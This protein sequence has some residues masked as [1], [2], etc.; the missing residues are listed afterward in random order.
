MTPPPIWYGV[1]QGVICLVAALIFLSIHLRG[2][3]GHTTGEGGRGPRDPGFLWLS[4]AVFVWS[5]TGVLAVVV[6]PEE[7]SSL[8]PFLSTLNSAFL[9]LAASSLA[10]GMAF[11][12]KLSENPR[13]WLFVLSVTAGTSIFTL[14]MGGWGPD[15]LLSV[16]T[17]TVLTAGLIA[18]FGARSFP[19]LAAL[20]I[21][22]VLILVPQIEEVWSITEWLGWSVEAKW[23]LN[24][25]AKT[26]F[27]SVLLAL[28][29]SWAHA[30]AEQA[31][32]QAVNASER[33]EQERAARLAVEKVL[34]ELQ[35]KAPEEPAADEP[36]RGDLLVV[37]RSG[38]Y[39]IEWLGT[40]ISSR[41]APLSRMVLIFMA[42]RRKSQD[43][44]DGYA[45]SLELGLLAEGADD[46]HALDRAATRISRLR[47]DLSTALI[48]AVPIY[49][50]FG[51][52]RYRLEVEPRAI[53]LE[54]EKPWTGKYLADALVKA[55]LPALS[56]SQRQR[57]PRWEDNDLKPVTSVHVILDRLALKL[58]T[59]AQARITEQLQA[60]GFD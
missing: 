39:R 6:A 5:A 2:L 42:V 14:V 24:L 16:T 18:T 10:Y 7:F 51:E 9:L 50:G 58:S 52:K 44:A 46:A 30:E 32:G 21:V 8:R 49:T 4:S 47:A 17:L 31:A 3:P 15:F 53:K 43:E 54:F 41:L 1:S 25:V 40:P 57:L 13:W 34:A 27:I 38:E 22:V 36:N 37:F 26:C 60:C 20:S 56:S 59:Q 35:G 48:T 29:T 23:A 12:E 19:M 28:P 11:L 45:G 55:I 33:L